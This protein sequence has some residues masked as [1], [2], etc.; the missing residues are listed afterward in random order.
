MVNSEIV[1]SEMSNSEITAIAFPV[2][3]IRWSQ[4]EQTTPIVLQDENGPCPLIALVNTLLLASD[5]QARTIEIEQ[6]PT[7]QEG[8]SSAP[9]TNVR[10]EGADRIRE[11]LMEHT[12]DRVKLSKLLSLLGDILLDMAGLDTHVVHKLLENLPL[13]HTGLDVNPNLVT[14]KFQPEDLASQIFDAFGLNF[15]HGWVWEP[16]PGSPVNQVFEQLQ[17]FEGLQNFFCDDDSEDYHQQKEVEYWLQENSSQLTD[18]GLRNLDREVNADLV[19]IF[20]RNN[21]FSTLYK[22]LSDDSYLLVTDTAFTKLSRYVW[23]SLNS[24]SGNG[25]LFFTGDFVPVVEGD[26]YNASDDDENLRV[27]QLL[28]EEEDAAMAKRMQK[29]IDSKRKSHSKAVPKV[30]EQATKGEQ[31][32]KK[33]KMNCTI[34]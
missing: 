29:N 27:A 15:V 16:Q 3:T 10:K 1:N 21:H 33:K 13:L 11:L 34:V 31:S 28:Q 24:V 18:Y 2:K 7:P 17:T 8:T 4:Y 30:E 26:D 5:I 25:D 12:G 22:G 14:G 20:F 23:Q 9:R 6:D 32:K 19:A